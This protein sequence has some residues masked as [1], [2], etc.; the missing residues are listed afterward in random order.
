M[1][2]LSDRLAR[3]HQR[4]SAAAARAGRTPDTV[5]L[6][7]VSKKQDAHKVRAAAAAG[8]RVFGESYVQEATAKQ[9]ACS[10]LDVSWHMVGHLQKNKAKFVVGRFALLHTLDSAALAR[11]LDKRAR[12]ADV[13]VVNALIEINIAGEGTKS[14][15]APAALPELLEAVETCER[16]RVLG[17]MTMPP[18]AGDPRPHFRTC[19]ELAARHNLAELSMGMS[20][21]FE[22]AIEEGATLIRVGTEIFGART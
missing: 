13:E 6:V 2:S 22:I 16:L 12:A 5:T 15:V 9:D 3:V 19:A 20:S 21:D 4:I 7:A 17:L 8:H 18:R 11:E 14:G 1:E 10:D